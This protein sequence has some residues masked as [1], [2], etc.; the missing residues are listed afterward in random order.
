[1]IIIWNVICVLNTFDVLSL[2]KTYDLL[3]FFIFF[4]FLERNTVLHNFS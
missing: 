2:T 1:M 4:M 3:C